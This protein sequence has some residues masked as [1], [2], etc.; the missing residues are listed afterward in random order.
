MHYTGRYSGALHPILFVTISLSD[1]VVTSKC[2]FQDDFRARVDDLDILR[3]LRED[4]EL[5]E[6]AVGPLAGQ[7]GVAA[8][9]EAS[10]G[11]V[12]KLLAQARADNGGVP[13][14]VRCAYLGIKSGGVVGEECAL[15]VGAIP[16]F[17]S[18]S[19]SHTCVASGDWRWRAY[20]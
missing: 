2:L 13:A 8:R 1:P 10:L 11:A 6:A 20:K 9:G 12:L 7:K 4:E 15:D 18:I 17:D 14:V 19:R 3:V 5:R 16:V